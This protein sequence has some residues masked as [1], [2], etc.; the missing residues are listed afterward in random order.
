MLENLKA[1]I[2]RANVLLKKE[3]LTAGTA[4]NVSGIE[5][6]T[7]LIVIKPSGVEYDDLCEGKMTVIDLE[8]RV[9]E[10]ALKP[11]VDAPHHIYIYKNM[12]ETGSVAHTHS[13]YATMFAIAGNPIPVYS[14]AHADTFGMDVPC[15]PYVDNKG[16]NIG[17]AILKYRRG[18]C[19]AVLMARHGVFVFEKTSKQAVN[20]S[21]MLEHVAKTAKGAME[22]SRMLKVDLSPMSPE[23]ARLWYARHHGGGYGQDD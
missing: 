16:E 19:P 12:P 21:I 17:K 15:A 10:G 2:C 5:R 20:V 7:G 8:G 23:D 18:G 22:L 4:G 1:E 13:P 11:S 6:R 14:T 3:G 9:V